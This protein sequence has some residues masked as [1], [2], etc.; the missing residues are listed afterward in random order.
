MEEVQRVSK[1]VGH[2][3]TPTNGDGK[4]DAAPGVAS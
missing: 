1:T 4:A 2:G 3:T